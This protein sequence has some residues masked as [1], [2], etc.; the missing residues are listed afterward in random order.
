M[1]YLDDNRWFI[2]ASKLKYFL[3]FWPEAY[4]LKYEKEIPS[5]H[6]WEKD[7]FKL[8][9]A[10][11][12]LLSYG[13]DEFFKKYAIKEEKLLKDDIKKKLDEK[14][15]EYS[16]SA[17]VADLEGLYYGDDKQ[18]ISNWDWKKILWM[19]NEVMRQPLADAKWEYQTQEEVIVNYKNLKLK[20]TLDRYSKERKLIRDWKTSG[21][22]SYFEYNLD[23]TFDYVLS[24]AYYFVLAKVRD[25]VECDV[26]LD[27]LWTVPP[28]PY[29]GYQLTKTQLIEKVETKIVPWLEA[30]IE[31]YEKCEWKSVYPISYTTEGKHWD[32]IHH[33]AWDPI[34]RTKLMKSG[35]YDQ[36][37]GWLQQDFIV[38]SF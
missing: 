5:T 7:Y 2:T 6:E 23:T 22:V 32:I 34:N 29:Y 8:G 17:K 13:A 26:M 3:S 33:E 19:Y 31:C 4:Y 20:W 30:L 12:D 1:S 21:N 35:F 14:W 18:L 16:K 9:T 25:W 37:E 15:I 11:D 27:V 36:I 24:M 38:P 10:F 28:Y